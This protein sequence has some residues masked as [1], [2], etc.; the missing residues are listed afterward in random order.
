MYNGKLVIG[1]TFGFVGND[2]VPANNLATWDGEEWQELGG[3]A[4]QNVYALEVHKSDLIVAGSFQQLGN[5]EALCIGKWNGSEWSEL[6]GGVSSSVLSLESV[7]DDLFVGGTF[8]RAAGEV[9]NNIVKWNDG[10]WLPLGQGLNAEVSDIEWYNDSLWIAGDF[11]QDEESYTQSRFLIK[12]DGVQYWPV[13]NDVHGGTDGYVSKLLATSK[14]LFITGQFLNVGSVVSP[15]IAHYK[16]GVW[17]SLGLG[18]WGEGEALAIMGD[19]LFV[20]GSFTRAGSNADNSFSVFDLLNNVWRNNFSEG[21]ARSFSFLRPT[22]LAT[23]DD[24]LYVAGDFLKAGNLVTPYLAAWDKKTKR[25]LNLGKGVD[26]PVEEIEVRGKEVFVGGRFKRAGEVSARYLARWDEST[27]LWSALGEGAVRVVNALAADSSGV[28]ASVFFEVNEEQYD[29]YLGKWDG[30]AW[31][32]IDCAFYGYPYVIERNAGKT[33]L[34]GFIWT[35]EGDRV[36]NIA[37]HDETGWYPLAEGFDYFPYSLAFA[38]S[39][40]FAGGSFESSGSEPISYV[41]EYDGSSWLPLESG[42]DGTVRDITFRNG[43]LYTAGFF[44]NADGEATLGLAQW[45]GKG[46][47]EVA[48]GIDDYLF[49]VT[50]DGTHLYIGGYVSAVGAADIE[51]DRLARLRFGDAS[52]KAGG[53]SSQFISCYFDRQ[54]ESIR[55]NAPDRVRILRVYDLLGRQ[56]ITNSS[57]DRE[58]DSRDL[59]D[60]TYFVRADTES[61]I[62]YGKLI[63]RR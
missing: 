29:N 62:V 27:K 23:S 2:F 21:A 50:H 35:V 51:V 38:P 15:K 34:G 18:L 39:K 42:V 5:T 3:G 59:C 55:F 43:I 9:V 31:Q 48:G 46:W 14:G 10:A 28:Y 37:M 57:N 32:R 11:F 40:L 16:D 12:W 63:I 36:N 20:G 7:G 61:G 52:V 13:S 60:G 8:F 1:G 19:S 49:A 33:Y 54:N 4:D 30:S 17:S 22:V 25:W 6:D 58:I 44:E 47:S 45:D 56:L 26:G 24:Y 41:G 53:G